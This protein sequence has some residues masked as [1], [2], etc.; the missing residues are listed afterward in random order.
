MKMIWIYY[1]FLIN[2][3]KFVS[4]YLYFS[5]NLKDMKD[6]IRAGGSFFIVGGGGRGGR[7]RGLH[8]ALVRTFQWTS[9]EFSFIPDFLAENL[10]ADQN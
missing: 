10:N 9:S 3:H 1:H 4:G 5:S 6:H 8:T 2:P 7:S